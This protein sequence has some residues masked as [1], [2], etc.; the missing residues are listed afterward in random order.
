MI[1]PPIPRSRFAL[2]YDCE[3]GVCRNTYSNCSNKI[4]NWALFAV[5]GPFFIK[6]RA[7]RYCHSFTL[8][9]LSF[10]SVYNFS[11]K[12]RK[13][14]WY[15]FTSE[16]NNLQMNEGFVQV[17]FAAHASKTRFRAFSCASGEV[18]LIKI[19]KKTWWLG[20]TGTMVLSNPAQS[21]C[22]VFLFFCINDLIQFMS[23]QTEILCHM[24]TGNKE[25]HHKARQKGKSFL[26]RRNMAYLSHKVSNTTL[27][28]HLYLLYG[29][30]WSVRSQFSPLI[31]FHKFSPPPK[32][33]AQKYDKWNEG[34][35]GE[36]L[37]EREGSWLTRAAGC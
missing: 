15:S 10:A 23:C 33:P 21:A 3:P 16:T 34:V 32:I 35:L 12:K 20:G 24:H 9:S 26:L 19:K 2:I 30:V 29:S 13:D 1:F 31:P 7:S 25:I 36:R 22:S 17:Q 18:K 11:L 27:T 37:S 5:R 4:R 6:Q 28:A 14:V 8:G